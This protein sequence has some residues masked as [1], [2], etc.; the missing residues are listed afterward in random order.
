M[1]ALCLIGCAQKQPAAVHVFVNALPRLSVPM[2]V[3][4]LPLSMMV[5]FHAAPLDAVPLI[6]VVF[7]MRWLFCCQE[8]PFCAL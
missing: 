4:L 7:P 8:V 3:L 5:W 2:M 1:A 6:I